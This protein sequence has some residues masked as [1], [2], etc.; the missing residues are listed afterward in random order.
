[1]LRPIG[2]VLLLIPSHSLLAD[3][4]QVDM[5]QLEIKVAN[6]L[7][8]L[9]T[10]PMQFNYHFDKENDAVQS[11]VNFQ[12]VISTFSDRWTFTNRF[13]VPYTT[14]ETT[15]EIGS[16]QT[17]GFGDFNYQLYMT[18]RYVSDTIFGGGFML[19]MPTG[20]GD[21]LSTGKWGVGP[22][23]A[24]VSSSPS[25]TMGALLYQNWSIAGD[26]EKK[27]VNLL[28]IQPITSYRL[29]NFWSISPF[30]N[31]TFDGTQDDE[32]WTVPLGLQV[33]K[34]FPRPFVPLSTSAGIFS[35]VIRPDEAP[36]WSMKFQ[37]TLIL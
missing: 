3:E 14:T 19:S 18:P 35:N 8:D 29:G 20:V 33:S 24:V 23:F 36:E 16:T 37:L 15:T 5:Y 6:P 27:D 28:T 4:Y 11:V 13:I 26:D 30:N 7:S 10:L 21:Q 32:Q 9:T 2:I 25:W 1:M 22:T 31:I 34:L 17:S 12:P